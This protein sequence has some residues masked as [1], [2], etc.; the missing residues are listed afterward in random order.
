MKNVT[1]D[2]PKSSQRDP[3]AQDISFCVDEL[4]ALPDVPDM[5]RRMENQRS[6]FKTVFIES[7]ATTANSLYLLFIKSSLG[8]EHAHLSDRITIIFLACPYPSF[9]ASSPTDSPLPPPERQPQRLEGP[10]RA[11]LAIRPGHLQARR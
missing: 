6:I 3:R 8:L 4:L 11:R 5:L 9:S 7:I 2:R 10:A 1:N